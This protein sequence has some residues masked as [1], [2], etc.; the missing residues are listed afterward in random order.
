MKKNKKN[1]ISEE[2][3]KIKFLIFYDNK[4]TLS[5]NISLEEQDTK[6]PSIGVTTSAGKSGI[7][8][9][10]D[11]PSRGEANYQE[12][13]SAPERAIR[14][15]K[16]QAGSEGILECCCYY[17]IPGIGKDN[18]E[19]I[20]GMYIPRNSEI[21]FWG[22]IKHYNDTIDEF[23]K[24]EKNKNINV[25]EE[26]F[27]NKITQIFPPNTVRQIKQAD[28]TTYYPY[29]ATTP[30]T[31][32]GVFPIIYFSGFFNDKKEPFISQVISDDRN[33][34]QKF[35]DE[36]GYL[37]QWS[38]AGITL[39]GSI[40]ASAYGQA[41]TL[42]LWA[43][44]FLEQSIGIAIG[45]REIQK[46]HDVAGYASYIFGML[47]LLKFSNKFKGYDPKWFDELAQ[48]FGRSKLTSSSKVSEYI[49]FYKKLNKPKRE[50]LDK[51]LRGAD[52]QGKT[53]ILTK[54]SQ[55]AAERLPNLLENGFQTMWKQ[56]PKLFKAI[57]KFK[58][59]WVR[60]LL[61]N[62]VVGIA[63]YLTAYK[64]P[65][66]SLA[67][68]ENVDPIILEKLD[69]VYENIPEKLKEEMGYYLMSDPERAFSYLN[70]EELKTVQQFSQK[71]LD[72]NSDNVSNGLINLWAKSMKDVAKKTNNDWNPLAED[73]FQSEKMSDQEIQKLKDRGFIEKSNLDPMQKF[74]SLRFIN[75][76]YYVKPQKAKY[77]EKTDTTRNK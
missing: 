37:V 2:L 42:P 50:I 27:I 12:G 21:L 62:M 46:G 9:D 76:I 54:I 58:R 36:W 39:I 17:P 8:G 40:I 48:D 67:T 16:T 52:I 24:R 29:L 56:N 47:P 25:N 31:V 20:Q 15:P 63:S 45:I 33:E 34:I 14:P 75:D 74:D 60:E 38:T 44:L 72:K 69:G 65:E 35:I 13:C 41:W 26:Y 70:S 6:I 53:D 66:W 57:P 7:V 51:I 23:L 64:N 77:D 19:K 71:A 68:S 1:I 18:A 55:E 61:S 30:Y 43:E 49:S 22:D 59:L 11:P 10:T 3:L 5:E 4:K 32:N 73:L 28:G